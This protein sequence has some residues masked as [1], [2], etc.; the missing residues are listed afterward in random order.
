[1]S[2]SCKYILFFSTTLLTFASTTNSNNFSGISIFAQD[3]PKN[4]LYQRR[5]PS[6]VSCSLFN[7]LQ[8]LGATFNFNPS[9]DNVRETVIVLSNPDLLRQAINLKRQGK[10]KYLLAGPNLVVRPIECDRLVT[11]PEIDIYFVPSLWVK[12]FYLEDEPC[13]KNRIDIWPTG[14]DETFWQPSKTVSKNNN[15]LLYQKTNDHQLINN[16]IKI[17]KRNGFNPL[18]IVYGNYTIEE[19]K[20]LL[21]KSLFAVFI[22]N[23]ESQGIALAEAWSMNIPTLVYNLRK[24]TAS[25][26]VCTINSFCPYLTEQTGIDWRDL[27]ELEGWIKAIPIC[28]EDFSP[29]NWVL[30]NM[31][32]CVSAQHILNLIKN[33]ITLQIGDQCL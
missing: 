5:G 19:Y 20:K 30:K 31:T 3:S 8:K 17:L 10:I 9:K 11:A 21:D 28:L 25:G 23:S 32:D 4:S 16:V 22:G 2:S 7:G 1:M 24:Y 18:P 6:S 12:V 14:V 26:K 27:E 33:L 29:R 15:V 13:L